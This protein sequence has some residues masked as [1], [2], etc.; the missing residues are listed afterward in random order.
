M[1]IK[2]T[3][4]LT[5]MVLI[6]CIQSKISRIPCNELGSGIC[7][8][9]G[10]RIFKM[11]CSSSHWSVDANDVRDRCIRDIAKSVHVMGYSYFAAYEEGNSQ[12]Q[13]Y[14]YMSNEAVTTHHNYNASTNS[15]MSVYG[16]GRAAGYSAYGYGNSNTNLSGTS[17]SYIPV[18]HTGTI[19]THQRTMVFVP[20]S[21]DELDNK[22]YFRVSDY[23]NAR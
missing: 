7:D 18:Q 3:L 11:D 13:N 4:I 5:S 22:E 23:Y 21:P 6:G 19:T 20:L 12:S 8:R 2:F 10:D 15:N 14:T 9:V 17:T 1:R 16:G